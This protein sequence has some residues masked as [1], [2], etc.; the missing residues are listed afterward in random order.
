[1]KQLRLA[2]GDLE[3]DHANHEAWLDEVAREGR[4]A[5]AWSTRRDRARIGWLDTLHNASSASVRSTSRWQ[6]P[7]F[8]I[9]ASVVVLW[10]WL[11]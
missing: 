7:I 8:V 9:V 2:T 11:A 1:M 3:L 5:V 6:L 4:P 10:P